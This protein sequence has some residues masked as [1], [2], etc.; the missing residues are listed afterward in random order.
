MI[1]CNLL[2]VD[3]K[4]Q[5]RLR[6]VLRDRLPGFAAEKLFLTATHIHTGPFMAEDIL[7]RFWGDEF[8]YSEADPK[9]TKPSE[10]IGFLVAQLADAAAEAWESRA[11]GGISRESGYAALSYNRRVVYTD[12]TAVMYGNTKT[13]SFDMLEGP[14]DNGVE[15]LYF[16][17]ADRKLT[18]VAVNTNCPAQILEHKRYITAD[19]W[20]EVRKELGRRFGRELIVLPLLGSAGDL[21]PRDLIRLGREERE[22]YCE[23]MYNE[24]GL[25]IIARRLAD[26]VEDRLAEAAK[27]IRFGIAFGHG[28]REVPLPTRMI[29]KEEAEQAGLQYA[30]WAEKHASLKDLSESELMK[31]SFM[32]AKRNRAALQEIKPFYKAEVHVIRL[33]DAV[34][35]TNPF[36]LFL[37]Y[38]M[39]IKARNRAAQTFI[40]QLS[41]DYGGYLPTERA[42]AGGGYSANVSNGFVGPEA[43]EILVIVT[44]EMINDL[45]K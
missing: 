16:W 2:S 10:Y 19:Y 37:V 20:G 14:E 5:E 18:G 24:A 15:L 29:S 41:C 39:R 3:E 11:P 9:I 7:S 34:I 22:M 13:D 44:V 27:E 35:A 1:S 30:G 4:L 38:G 25:G 40:T 31:L 21:S 17:N 8:G 33:G 43:G 23:P 12:G 36:E 42:I 6:S 32:L 26:V 45:F 28:I